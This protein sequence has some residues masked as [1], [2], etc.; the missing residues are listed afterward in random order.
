LN[1]STPELD[2]L[3]DNLKAA[4]ALIFGIDTQVELATAEKGLLPPT[5]EI[6]LLLAGNLGHIENCYFRGSA[7]E[8]P[9]D[10][11]NPAFA[12]G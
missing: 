7:L 1:L 6:Q 12:G 3:C 10:S 8:Q 2:H 9:G 11:Q 4:S 5:V